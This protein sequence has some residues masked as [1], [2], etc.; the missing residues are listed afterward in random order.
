MVGV[1]KENGDIELWGSVNKV[2]VQDAFWSSYYYI[3]RE[4]FFK[5]HY[6]SPFFSLNTFAELDNITL[7]YGNWAISDLLDIQKEFIW[8]IIPQ[9][10]LKYQMNFRLIG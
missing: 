10:N 4:D 2:S 3:S 7:C 9:T 5:N 1:E 8:K 6:Q